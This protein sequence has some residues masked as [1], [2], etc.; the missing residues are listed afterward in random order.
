MPTLFSY[1]FA[2]IASFAVHALANCHLPIANCFSVAFRQPQHKM[3][4]NVALDL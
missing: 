2:L 1:S 4:N 3:P